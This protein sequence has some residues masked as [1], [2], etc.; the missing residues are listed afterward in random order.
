VVETGH[1]AHLV[2][3]E[4]NP[5]EDIRITREIGAVVLAGKKQVNNCGRG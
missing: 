4:A 1:A 2:L 5:L 3:L